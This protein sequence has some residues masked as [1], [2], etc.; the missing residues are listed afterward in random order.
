MAEV[1]LPEDHRAAVQLLPPSQ[2]PFDQDL[3]LPHKYLSVFFH[4]DV[5]K[6]A[7]KQFIGA[8]GKNLMSIRLANPD[9]DAGKAVFNGAVASLPIAAVNKLRLAVRR[10]CLPDPFAALAVKRPPEGHASDQSKPKSSKGDPSKSDPSKSD[11]S[12]SSHSS[13]RSS[14]G[15]SSKSKSSSKVTKDDDAAT[16]SKSSSSKDGDKAASSKSLVDYE[17]VSDSDF[18]DSDDDDDDD[19]SGAEEKSSSGKT[20]EVKCLNQ[21]FNR[22][23]NDVSL[24]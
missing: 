6:A 13:G 20:G 4:Y 2:N 3:G 5:P 17:N 10:L 14:G 15:S 7:L 22:V 23:A 16:A 24:L 19:G 8:V 1:E 11:P 12:K 21:L 9:E 18:S